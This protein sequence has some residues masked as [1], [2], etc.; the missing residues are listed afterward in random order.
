MSTVL[1]VLSLAALLFLFRKK[2]VEKRLFLLIL[3]GNLL[4]LGLTVR[5]NLT[6]T[7]IQVTE[8]ERGERGSGSAE[9]P[10]EILTENGQQTEITLRVPEQTFTRAQT[11]ELLTAKLEEL[12]EIILGENESF[13]R[14]D[15]NLHLPSSFSDSP[16]TVRWSTDQPQVLNWDGSIGEG[17]EESGTQV[18]LEGVLV[19]QD[20]TEEYRRVLTVYPSEEEITLETA[21]QRE[22]DR[23]N[24]QREGE[25]YLLPEEAGGQK[26]VWYRPAEQMG[27]L[28]SGLSLA[29]GA[30]AVLSKRQEEEKAARKRKEE[31]QR[32]YPEIVSKMQLLAGAG[33]AMRK[34]FERIAEDYRKEREADAGKENRCVSGTG[35]IKKSSG[36]GQKNVK[37]SRCG[38]RAAYEEIVRICHEM[39]NGVSEAEVYERL[40][41]R[42]GTASYRGLSM[43]LLQNL[44][45]GSQG[46]LPLL[47]QEA[48]EAFE[49]RKRNAR[50]EGEKAAV[51]LLLPMGL[52]LLVV[53]AILM[54]PALLAL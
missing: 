29:A 46:L 22:A 54:V 5:E 37:S 3:C 14:I 34:V 35:E 42:C 20:E 24:E 27:A 43:I 13:S 50:T 2:K 40:G 12:D 8:L 39:K 25:T 52:M 47:E 41:E 38:K 7:R 19:L 26:L 6:G 11:E 48:R 44:K 49:I 23:L 31:L 36:R 10:M 18:C 15:H 51:R 33:L 9:V 45:K 30:A 21:V 32:D 53:L 28:V 4:G 1:P 17:P 16:V